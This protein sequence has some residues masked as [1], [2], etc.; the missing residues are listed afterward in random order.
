MKDIAKRFPGKSYGACVSRWHALNTEHVSFIQIS[1][2]CWF[3]SAFYFKISV[4]FWNLLEK[5]KRIIFYNFCSHT[6]KY[7][8]WNL[9]YAISEPF[10]F[11]Q[12]GAHLIPRRLHCFFKCIFHAQNVTSEEKKFLKVFPY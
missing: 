2:F 5:K 7:V 9:A 1:F 3:W 8:S 4:V 11:V 6:P 12:H 10:L